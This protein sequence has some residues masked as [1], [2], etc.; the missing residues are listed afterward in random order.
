MIRL[1]EQVY[2][3]NNRFLYELIQNAEDNLYPDGVVP[4]LSFTLEPG[5]IVVDSNESGFTIPNIVAICKI[6]KST[7]TG[8]KKYIGE[9]G[10]GFKSVFNVARK[11]HVQ[12]E[13]YSFAFEHS[14]G[15]D[16]LGMLTP[17]DEEYLDVPDWVQTRMILYLREDCNLAEC[18]R[19]FLDLPETLLLFLEKLKEISVYIGLPDY[20]EQHIEYCLKQ[21]SD[22]NNH[23]NRVCV[24]KKIS[25][26][27]MSRHH[28][29]IKRRLIDDM[30]LHEA[31]KDNHRAEVV[32]AFPLDSD[33]IPIC[34]EEGQYIYAFLPLRREPFK[35]RI[36]GHVTG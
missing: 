28:F 3:S 22:A 36:T 18:R 6:A 29:W 17:L 26:E 32:L 31:R 16:G 7:K 27:P 5:R 23:N 19:D 20:P 34:A 25:E 33:D 9:K 24:E 10:I 35:V 4:R 21:S 11:V 13:P 15:D 12:S 14:P 8:Q 30:P 2:T 1:A